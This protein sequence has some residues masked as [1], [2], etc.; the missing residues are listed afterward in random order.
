VRVAS[1]IALFS[2][3]A[4]A[5][6]VP[7]GAGADS[8][9]SPVITNAIAWLLTQQEADGGFEVSNF[10]GFETAD[11]ILA[12][13]EAAQTTSTWNAADA[14]AAVSTTRYNGS[15]DTPLD[16]I[17]DWIAKPGGVNPGEAAKI[18]VLVAAPLGLDPT[19]FGAAHTDLAAIVYPSG[20]GDAPN[21]TS[22]FFNEVILVAL[23][24]EVLCG[25]PEAG[26]L[27]VIRAAQR[28]DGGWN[29]LGSPDDL[30][31]PADSDV[32]T[33]T[34]ALHALLAGGAAWNDDAVLDGLNFLSDQYEPT[35]GAFKGF[36]FDDPN[37]TATSMFA[38]TAAGFDP[39]SSCWR[40]T[41]DPTTA[42]APY[43]DP[44]GYLHALQ[45]PSGEIVGP[46]PNTFATTQSVEALLASWWP[47]T[48]ATGAPDCVPPDP[49]EP[50]GPT[51][52]TD[53]TDPTGPA[54]PL[55]QSIIVSPVELTRWF[56]G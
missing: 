51:D 37:A 17:D 3:M 28:S 4:L 43:L 45:A 19:D 30:P 55:D 6:A 12:I 52:P 35:T 13:A 18:I 41:V 33:T 29:F 48:R 2:L 47:L 42:S 32:D 8:P 10:Q 54:D 49:P 7:T 14:F 25:E 15:G 53:P 23:G 44:A 56:T 16:A 34:S 21:T 1:F 39:S 46:I 24:G 20:C 11:A 22:I 5:F 31:F 26:V 36:G 50:G 40:V 27:D 9:S 38:I